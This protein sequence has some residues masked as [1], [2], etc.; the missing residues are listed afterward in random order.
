M[1]SKNEHAV[2][3]VARE[4][5]QAVGVDVETALNTLASV[6]I[7]LHCWQGDDVA[8][9][10]SKGELTGGIAATGNHPG[11]ARTADEL[12][13]DLEQA[14][15]LLPGAHR[16][17][18]H[19]IYADYDGPRVPRDELAP[20]H[21]QRW[22]DW[23]RARGLGLDYNP[24]CFSHPLAADGLTLAHP[25]P[26]VRAFWIRHVQGSRRIGAAMGRA[27]GTAA[28]TNVWIPDGTKDTPADR[29]APRQRLVEALDACFE[30]A[31]DP[32]HNLDAV[33]SKLFGIGAESY[34][35][36]SHEFYMGYAA[37]RGKLVCLDAGHFHPTETLADKISAMLL[38]FP[39]LLLHVSRGVRWDSDHVVAFNDDLLALM[40]EI[41]RCDALRRV[42]IGLDYFDASINR[43][44]AWVIGTRNAR[45][46]LLAALLEPRRLLGE[47]E[48]AGDLAG[49]LALMEEMKL[50]PLGEVW[51]EFCRRHNV[52][53][54]GAWMPVVRAYEKRVL[55]TRG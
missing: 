24:T 26:A 23:A 33:E 48:A 40:Q 7:S 19:A 43:V 25:D 13:A 29:L 31:I 14:Y 37:A 41:V 53:V 11:K 1:M 4:R 12:R 50:M 54:D 35:V 39:E 9:F 6:P 21:F 44:A 52:P 22:I 2:F 49:R 28:V 47:L 10:E 8:G 51:N 5:Y 36:G 3:E 55:A 16:L 30:E 42:H 17:S 15:A 32:A 38:W 27:L 45:K 34:T 20:V 18:L 46:A